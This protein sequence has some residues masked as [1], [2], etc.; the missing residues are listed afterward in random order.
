MKV[1][2]KTHINIFKDKKKYKRTKYNLKKS[3]KIK[4]INKK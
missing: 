3:M 4:E 2:K 1:K